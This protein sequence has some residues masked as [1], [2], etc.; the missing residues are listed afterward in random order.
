MASRTA[1]RQPSILTDQQSADGVRRAAEQSGDNDDR[2]P[3]VNVCQSVDDGGGQYVQIP[4][5]RDVSLIG[6]GLCRGSEGNARLELAPFTLLPSFAWSVFVVVAFAVS[7]LAHRYFSR[8]NRLG[9]TE[10]PPELE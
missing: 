7:A 4:I 9:I 5:L 8:R 6:A 2:E 10:E 3:R 1:T